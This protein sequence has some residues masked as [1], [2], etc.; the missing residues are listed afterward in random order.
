[1]KQLFL[2]TVTSLLLLGCDVKKTSIGGKAINKTTGE[3]VYNVLVSYSQC[4]TNGDNCDEIVIGQT[5]TNQS[6]EFVIDKK[7]ASKSKTKWLTAFYNGKKVGQVDN[8]GLKDQNITVEII[9]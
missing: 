8:I 9:P 3:G 7:T 6:G 2:F 1:M 5:Y 4:K